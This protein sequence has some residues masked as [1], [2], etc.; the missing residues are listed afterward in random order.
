MASHNNTTNPENRCCD[1]SLAEHRATDMFLWVLVFSLDFKYFAGT[2][3]MLLN[4]QFVLIQEGHKNNEYSDSWS[5]QQKN[6]SES[7]QNK[8]H[9]IQNI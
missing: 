6:V 5:D 3:L 9:K 2:P 4:H 1:I 8:I 7:S